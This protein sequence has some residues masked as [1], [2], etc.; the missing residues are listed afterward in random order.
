MVFIEEGKIMA[1]AIKP[2]IREQFLISKYI[3]GNFVL[4]IYYSF[5]FSF[6]NYKNDGDK[7]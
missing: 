4:N 6:K 2:R 1:A 7:A 5:Y 3:K